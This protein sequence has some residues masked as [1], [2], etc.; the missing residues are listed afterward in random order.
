DP[1]RIDLGAGQQVVDAANAVP[2]AEETEVRA[3]KNQTAS[4]ILM[5]G[6]STAFDRRPAGPASRVLDAFALAERVVRQDDVA[7]AREIRKE[8]LVAGPRF[9]VHRMS[10]RPQNRG[11]APRLRGDAEIR[12]HVQTRPALE[13]QLLDAVA[14]PL[15]DARHLRVQRSALERTSQHLPQLFD[16]GSL[17]VENLL[18]GRDG[19]DDPAA[20]FARVVG[21]THEISLQVVGIVGQT[22]GVA[23]ELHTRR[24]RRTGPRRRLRETIDGGPETRRGGKGSRGFEE[25]A[26]RVRHPISSRA[27]LSPG[28]QKLVP[29]PA[30]PASQA[31]RTRSA[32]L[33]LVARRFTRAR[34]VWS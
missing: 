33:W 34:I 24:T 20:T 19:S 18:A 17:P 2:R 6:R 8:L 11:A 13:R 12:C 16:D 32:R 31:R 25:R 30:A 5:F 27:H 9:P 14:D 4:G 23:G 26:S 3:E 22:R 7:L 10:Q 21:Q 29:I 15:D 1:F 28:L